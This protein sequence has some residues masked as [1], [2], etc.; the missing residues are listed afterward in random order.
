MTRS[1]IILILMFSSIIASAQYDDWSAGEVYL[2][3]GKVL[4]GLVR[5]PYVENNMPFSGK[6]RL[7]Y[8]TERNK[9]SKKIKAKDVDKVL[10]KVVYS[11]KVKGKRIKKERDAIFIA[12]SRNKKN[13]KFGFA[14]LVVDGPLKL[15]RRAVSNNSG[16]RMELITESLFVKD[17]GMAIPF[18]YAEIKSFKKRAKAYF[19]DC[20]VLVSK[21]DNDQFNRKNLIEIA[22]FYNANCSN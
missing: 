13:T 12:I 18:N 15:V 10:L 22:Q 5:F 11:E 3:D 8:K 14:E 19:E 1:L 20:P 6:E 4:M 16:N 7:R 9:P 21:I 2:K 17:E